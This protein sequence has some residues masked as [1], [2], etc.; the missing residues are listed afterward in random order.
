MWKIA[1]LIKSASDGLRS[2]TKMIL[3]LKENEELII[4]S[5][6]RRFH[7]DIRKI[8]CKEGYLEGGENAAK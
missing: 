2:G 8:I 3:M 4:L 1:P 5:E 6:E 7:G